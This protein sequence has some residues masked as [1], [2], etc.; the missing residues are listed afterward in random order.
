MVII[1]SPIFFGGGRGGSDIFGP[2]APVKVLYSVTVN[3]RFCMLLNLALLVAKFNIY[4]CS[5]D[6]APVFFRVFET[7]LRGKAGIEYYINVRYRRS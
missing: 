7:E 3:S 6:E 5:L 4:R 2:P 1:M